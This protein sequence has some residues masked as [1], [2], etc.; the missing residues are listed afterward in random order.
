V[1]GGHARSL[2]EMAPRSVVARLTPGLVGGFSTYGFDEQGRFPELSRL[3][4]DDL[5]PGE[6]WLCGELVR[7]L[8]AEERARLSAAGAHLFDSPQRLLAE[9]GAALGPWLQGGLDL[10]YVAYQ[11]KHHLRK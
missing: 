4:A 1:A 9:V 3:H 6:F 7:A 2:Y 11:T 8:P 10:L 5:P